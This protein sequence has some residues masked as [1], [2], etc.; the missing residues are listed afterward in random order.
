MPLN[1]FG[2]TKRIHASKW[3][4]VKKRNSRS[5]KKPV[6]YGKNLLKSEIVRKMNFLLVKALNVGVNNFFLG[7]VMFG[8]VGSVANY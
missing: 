8:V 3:V 2:K 7:C 6:R 1:I 5:M 4:N